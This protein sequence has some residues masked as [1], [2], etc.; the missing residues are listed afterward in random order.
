M[1]IPTVRGVIDRRILVNYRVDPHILARILPEPFRPKLV[2]GVGIAGICLIRLNQI[3]PRFVPR[4]A[5]L[6]SENAAHRIAVE[7]DDERGAYAKGVFI[8]RRDTPS[9]FNAVAGGRLFPGV[10]HHARFQVDES[11]GRYRVLMNSDDG[12]TRVSISGRPCAE[13]PA[14]SIFD[15]TAA[16]SKFFQCGSVGYSPS[17]RVGEFDGLELRTFGWNMSPLQ[18]ETVE[19]S[20]F[21]DRALFPRASIEF[22]SAFLMRNIEHEWRQLPTIRGKSRTEDTMRKA[23]LNA[24][25]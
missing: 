1:R 13:P 24:V 8:P 20:L 3:R 17:R 19:S 10:H 4:F 25:G 23:A 9:R 15:A 22:D 21:D 7:W 18:L 11:A 12:E 14:T 5:G 2:E 16:A 6:T